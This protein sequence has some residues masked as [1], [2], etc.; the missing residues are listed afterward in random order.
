MASHRDFLN[1]DHLPDVLLFDAAK[2]SAFISNSSFRIVNIASAS[3]Q[4]RTVA[5]SFPLSSIGS[6]ILLDT[7]STHIAYSI[8]S[9]VY[10]ELIKRLLSSDA[11]S[12][13]TRFDSKDPVSSMRNTMYVIEGVGVKGA[14]WYI[15]EPFSALIVASHL[16]D[17][18]QL[19]GNRSIT[20][21]YR[22]MGKNTH[23]IK[24]TENR[25]L[26]QTPVIYGDMKRF[27]ILQINQAHKPS[28]KTWVD[29][30]DNLS[31]IFALDLKIEAYQREAAVCMKYEQQTGLVGG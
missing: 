25:L 16:S 13:P 26:V 19:I 20:S 31:V 4:T 8:D 2:K 12:P 23:L 30:S 27:V 24:P 3:P 29:D 14:E 10:T 22:Y 6:G 15:L 17:N 21:N 28:M 11:Y 1:F 9:L 7:L 18:P 5:F